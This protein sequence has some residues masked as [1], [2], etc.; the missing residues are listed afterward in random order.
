MTIRSYVS[1]RTDSL[2]RYETV[3]ASRGSNGV[4]PPATWNVG[5][6]EEWLMEHATSIADDR[7]VLSTAD[8]FEQG[9]DRYAI[10]KT[11][12]ALQYH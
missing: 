11:Q 9:F 8:L 5:A 12:L 2:T 1:F 10:L 4:V 3:E 6:V 7:E